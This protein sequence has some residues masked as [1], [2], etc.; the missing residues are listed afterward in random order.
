MAS[1]IQCRKV[2]YLEV[3][4]QGEIHLHIII[5]GICFNQ[6]KE[7]RVWD[8]LVS[9]DLSPSSHISEILKKTNKR[10][11]INIALRILFPAHPKKNLKSI[12]ITFIQY[13]VLE[14][15]AVNRFPAIFP[16]QVS[17]SGYS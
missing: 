16:G 7:Q 1:K 15:G 5:Y 13:I 12:Y 6:V 10:I 2:C 9:R 17:Q 14:Y 11:D 4:R 3:Q 8:I